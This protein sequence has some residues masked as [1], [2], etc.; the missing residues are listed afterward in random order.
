MLLHKSVIFSSQA[1]RIHTLCDF[2]YIALDIAQLVE[3]D[4][5]EY[6]C[7]AYN[8]HGEAFSIINLKI[9]GQ[10]V[11]DTSSQRP[12]D[13]ISHLSLLSHTL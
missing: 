8:K 13:K 1:S 6:K 2:G 5:G 7:R 9:S 11:L 10:D 3:S 12:G 4:A